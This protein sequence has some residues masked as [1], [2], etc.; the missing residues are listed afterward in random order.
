MSNR[1]IITW[2]LIIGLL[3][4]LVFFQTRPPSDSA[5]VFFLGLEIL[6]F[7]VTIFL[8]LLLFAFYKLNK[9]KFTQ[10][11]MLLSS[12]FSFI[13]LLTF[14]RAGY[15]L[16]KTQELTLAVKER[17]KHDHGINAPNSIMKAYFIIAAF[18]SLTF[19]FQ[20]ILWF[21]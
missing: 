5:S 9:L 14:I 15:L 13:F 1:T 8:Q 20:I 2:T 4:C 6:L 19:A 7:L 17:L 21:L 18:F 16:I 3:Y 10:V 11:F 12:I